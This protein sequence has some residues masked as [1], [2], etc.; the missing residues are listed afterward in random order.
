MDLLVPSYLR[1]ALWPCVQQLKVFSVRQDLNISRSSCHLPPPKHRETTHEMCFCSMSLPRQALCPP[2]ATEGGQNVPASIAGS[3]LHHR[4]REIGNCWQRGLVIYWAP[5]PW[6]VLLYSNY[7][8]PNNLLPQ[9][10][11]K[12]PCI[13]R[14][15]AKGRKGNQG[16]EEQND[17]SKVTELVS[18]ELGIQ[19]FLHYTQSSSW[20]WSKNLIKTHS[21]STNKKLC[22][23][24]QEDLLEMHLK[25]DES[26]TAC[27][28]CLESKTEDKQ[29][30]C[31]QLNC[32]CDLVSER[33]LI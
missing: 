16:T 12:A 24:L 15:N 17:H 19:S 31:R 23:S 7:R 30:D 6:L 26:C 13:S 1:A 10:Q 27:E 2:D 25:K 9:A 29:H 3:S 18:S 5:C 20:H 22:C 4:K 32:M 11:A 28:N 21:Q 14:N 8:H 33:W